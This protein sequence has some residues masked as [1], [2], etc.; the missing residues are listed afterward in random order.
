MRE[1][2][3]AAR[4]AAAPAALGARV[5]P[6]DAPLPRH[7]GAPRAAPHHPGE[8]HSLRRPDLPLDLRGR[9]GLEPR[10]GAPRVP[11][12]PVAGPRGAPRGGAAAAL[13]DHDPR[14]PGAAREV[15]AVRRRRG[16]RLPAGRWLRAGRRSRAPERE[17]PRGAALSRLL[18]PRG[19]ALVVGG[20]SGAGPSSAWRA[21]G[22]TAGG[23]A[24][25]RAAPGRRR[26]AA[27]QRLRPLPPPGVRRGGSGRSAR[28]AGVP[29]L[30]VGRGRDAA[31]RRRPAGPATSTT[32]SRPW[33]R[34]SRSG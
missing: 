1:V 17:L 30:P 12:R 20:P 33:R 27:P 2:A 13:R 8:A 28:A 6:V 16:A 18:Q 15:S 5:P 22:S 10:G 14:V 31:L 26:P 7:R 3:G 25:D 29:A 4:A 21:G 24:G 11:A 19:A 32:T 9:A 34:R 23:A